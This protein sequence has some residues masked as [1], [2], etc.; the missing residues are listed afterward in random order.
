MLASTIFF[1]L[2]FS[3]AAT[4]QYQ[5]V[6]EYAGSGFFNDWDFYN[7]CTSRLLLKPLPRGITHLSD[8]T[9]VDNLTNGDVK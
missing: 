1:A 5:M 9:L 2:F 4:A 8:P 7:N 6:K 3:S